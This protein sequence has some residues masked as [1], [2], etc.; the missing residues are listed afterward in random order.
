MSLL[1]ALSFGLPIVI[2]HK[3]KFHE[4]IENNVNGLLVPI[5]DIFKL[6]QA[7]ET[8]YKNHSLRAKISKNNYKLVRNKFTIRNNLLSY[9]KLYKKHQNI[10]HW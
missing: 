6:N 7:L 10:S 8:I 2:T 3:E 9:K 1:E 4:V 5:N